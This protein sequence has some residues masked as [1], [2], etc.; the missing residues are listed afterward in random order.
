MKRLHALP[1]ALLWL[2]AGAVLAQTVPVP[3]GS[4]DLPVEPGLVGADLAPAGPPP[5]TPTVSLAGAMRLALE[6]N[7][8]LLAAADSVATAR[9][10]ESS[11]RADFY[12]Q[13]TPLVGFSRDETQLGL[14]GRQR[15]PWTGGSLEASATTHDVRGALP[16]VNAEVRLH[17]TQPLLRGL[18]P[19]ATFFDL[20]NAQ[21]ARQTQERALSQTRQDLMV[22]VTQTYL[23]VIQQRQLLRVAQQSLK[24]SGALR[25]ASEARVKVG[26][27]SKLDVFRAELQAS[28]A[29]EA[30]VTA[31]SSLETA[32]ESFRLVL[33]ITPHAALEP[34]PLDLE[35][36]LDEKV[37]PVDT[38]LERAFDRRPEVA[39]AQDRVDDARRA[40][41]LATQNLLPQLDLNV[42]IA[43]TG[44]GSTLSDSLSHLAPEV[45]V[46][47][48]T[49]YPLQRSADRA[50]KAAGVIAL[51]AAERDLAEV[52]RTVEADVRSAARDLA[53][54][55]QSI[56]LQRGGL[57]FAEQ[58]HR[59]ATLR[60]QR[61]LASNF[62]V[63]DAEGNLV[64]ART[65]LVTLLTEY[66]VARARLRRATHDLDLSLFAPAAPAESQ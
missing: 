55:L 9:L 34:A 49:S 3:P 26:L 15:L 10:S 48:T 59:L 46:G 41:S 40:L 18:G 23:Q 24:R 30:M 20:H 17:L 1:A 66:V 35:A 52:R 65:A 7:T 5:E 61:G 19:N 29:S 36:Q 16:R 4:E 57:A 62:D 6:N 47:V 64:S 32:L 44:V 63:V 43:H 27:V 31:Q 42:D 13:L 21:R 50:R 58:Q 28:Q 54:I 11:T 37:E 53:R 51:R 39:E 14:D 38:L 2:V 8:S 22:Q 12:P 33:G 25:R 60:Y 56:E 45:G